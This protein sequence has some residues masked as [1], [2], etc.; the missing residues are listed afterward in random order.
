MMINKDELL[1]VV[2]ENNNP[3]KPLPR[4]EVHQKGIWHRTSHVWVLNS[5]GQILC[6]KRSLLKDSSPGKWEPF[7]GGHVEPGEEYVDNAF[8]ELQEELGIL[9]SKND[10]HLF[11]INKYERKKEFQGIHFLQWNGEIKD[12]KLEKEEIEKVKWFNID[13][14]S[15]LL[16]YKNNDWTIKGYEKELLEHLRRFP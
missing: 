7:F 3:V 12:L 9:V 1:F 6:Q 8:R 11:K 10:F 5:Q 4:K 16:N 15:K 14:L 2:D 13:E